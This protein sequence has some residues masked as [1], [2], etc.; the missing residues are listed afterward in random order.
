MVMRTSDFPEL[1]DTPLRK[2]WFDYLKNTP[3][4]YSQWIN[5]VE[6][7][8]PFEDDLRMAE[9]GVVSQHTEGS[10]PT[11][12]DAGYGTT[13]RYEPLE[14][15]HGYVITQRMRE[16]DQHGIM[17][18]MTEALRKSF[19]NLFEVQSYRILNNSTSTSTAREKGFDTLALLSTAH[20]MLGVGVSNQA[21]RPTVDATIGQT[22]I[23]NA[24]KAFHDWKGEKGLP[25][26]FSPDMAI[27]GTG[28]QFLAA[29][30]FQN[31]KRYD[32]ANNEDNW[33]K[34][35]PDS[36]GISKFI[37]TRY[38]T[39]SNQ[40]YIMGKPHDLNLFIR[41]HPQFETNLDFAT[42]NLQA[43]G[44]ARL[45]SSFGLWWNVY[46]SSGY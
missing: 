42:G 21:N 6:T 30:L 33:I 43:K 24:V 39:A 28:D 45:I 29:K 1:L 7:S 12:E 9:F 26:M 41:I 3:A 4:E 27:V 22:S 19:R 20:T 32:T 5:T 23:E 46:G 35:G 10:T 25:A 18:R 16:D 44:R 8:K 15:S 2:V 11:F 34:R 14:Y 31:A 36:N 40:W 17:V 37:P 13:K 38:F